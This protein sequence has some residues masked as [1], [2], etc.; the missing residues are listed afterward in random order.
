MS[1]IYPPALP[2]P[3]HSMLC[4]YGSGRSHAWHS[5][6]VP[7]GGRR[8]SGGGVNPKTVV[9]VAKRRIE[10]RARGAAV[11]LDLMPPGAAPAGPPPSVRRTGRVL[12]RGASVK[13][14][15]VPVAAPFVDVVGHTAKA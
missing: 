5:T 2:R 6:R 1:K 10:A 7:A 14:C 15:G 4:N 11:E 13:G 12:S 9:V 3:G 8:G